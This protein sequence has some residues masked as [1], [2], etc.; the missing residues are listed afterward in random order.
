[1][2]TAATSADRSGYR[3][4]LTYAHTTSRTLTPCDISLGSLTALEAGEFVELILLYFYMYV[5]LVLFLYKFEDT[6]H[7][8]SSEKRLF[9]LN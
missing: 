3:N 2:I 6:R 9:F 8:F 7:M 4:T 5:V 1:V